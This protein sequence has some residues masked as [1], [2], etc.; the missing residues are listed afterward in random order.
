MKKAARMC[1]QEIICVL[2]MHRS[3]TSLLTRILNLIGVDLG[4]TEGLTT[5]PIAANPKGYWEHHQLTAISDAILKRY[6]GSWDKP[7]LLPRGWETDG[8]IDDL[9]DRAEQLIRD[10]FAEVPLW[11]WKDPRTCLTLPFWQRLLPNLRYIICLR[12]PVDV[13]RS[14]E[15]RDRLSAEMSSNLWITY[16]SFALRYSDGKPRLMIFYEDIM[17]DGL[18]ELQRLAEFLGRPERAEQADVKEAV[19]EF[20]DPGL[21]HQRASISDVAAGSRSELCARALYISHRIS[22]SFSRNEN[23]R[24][25][26][27]SSINDALEALSQY[28]R[29]AADYFSEPK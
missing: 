6:G 12:N 29:R 3:G 27:D 4:P 25:G 8:A 16:V 26:L 14:L 15:Q 19:Q 10:Q 5:E 13:A 2:G 17:N 22:A 11:G 9:R 21:Q 24:E 20:I 7:P 1:D 18:R 23:S 28:A